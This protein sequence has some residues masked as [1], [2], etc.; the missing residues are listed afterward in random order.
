M[1]KWNMQKLLKIYDNLIYRNLVFY[2]GPLI[3]LSLSI[4]ENLPYLILLLQ[5]HTNIM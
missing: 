2:K 1:E 5:R 3:L 4:N